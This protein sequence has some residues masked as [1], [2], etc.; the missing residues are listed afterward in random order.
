MINLNGK[1]DDND[2][3][4]VRE[5]YGKPRFGIPAPCWKKKDGSYKSINPHESRFLMENGKFVSVFHVKPIYYATLQGLWRPLSEVA[6]YYG[7]K[8]GMTLKEGWEQKMDMGYLVWY[9]KRLEAMKSQYGVAVSYP[10]TYRGIELSPVMVPVLLNV[11]PLTAY[12]DADPETT[13]VDGRTWEGTN[14]EWATIITAAGDGATDNE[15]V[16]Q[17]VYMGCAV[18]S[19]VWDQITRSI[20]LF[21]VSSMAGGNTDSATLTLTSGASSDTGSWA[22]AVGLVSSAPASNT[23]L[24]AGDYDSLGTTRYATD[25]SWT[26]NSTNEFTFNATG[27]S[28]IDTAAD[29]DGILKLGVKLEDD[30]DASAPT[31]QSGEKYLQYQVY[32]AETANTTS[33]PKLV[34]EYSEI[35]AA[36]KDL[37][38]G[39]FVL[40]P[41]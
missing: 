33:D 19:Q 29:G 22:E 15:E 9:I 23:T 18:T 16:N 32:F 12:P 14:A 2:L 13:T 5:R 20:F 17:L 34:V 37:I 28:F 1:I 11:S 24:A 10:Q 39:G 6:S 31:W 7:N 41:R 25:I 35:T 30:I 3:Q 40:F 36:I 26:A 38:G 27:K 21:D 8:R 4:F